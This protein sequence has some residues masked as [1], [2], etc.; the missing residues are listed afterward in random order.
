MNLY[1]EY[2]TTEKETGSIRQNEQA[3]T[4][5]NRTCDNESQ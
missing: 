3:L 1:A 2:A 4:Q 5:T